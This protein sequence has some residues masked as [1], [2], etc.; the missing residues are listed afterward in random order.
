MSD[1][2]AVIRDG[3]TI[4]LAKKSSSYLESELATEEGFF[5]F[6]TSV[7]PDSE[8]CVDFSQTRIHRYHNGL[9]FSL[10]GL[11]EEADVIAEYMEICGEGELA[12]DLGAYC[13]VS[14][15]HLA[16]R[17]NRVVAVEPDPDAYACL[18]ENVGRHD[19]KNVTTLNI[20]VMDSDLPQR[21]CADGQPGSHIAWDWRRNRGKVIEV[22][23]KTLPGL[24]IQYGEPEFVKM[25]IE[26]A[27]LQVLGLGTLPRAVFAVDAT[28]L[29]DHQTTQER[30]ET[31][32]QMRGFK[33]KATEL[34]TVVGYPQNA[35]L[36]YSS[37]WPD[38]QKFRL[39]RG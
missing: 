19:L 2:I 18:V 24:M 4:Y 21:F 11:P 35:W 27:E 15:Y 5:K 16:K 25:D 3:K 39:V 10:C 23:A 36:E 9:E 32:L 26:G 6:Y 30:V 17:F 7:V 1:R 20:A 37:E 14:T 28:H 8:D 33:T 29:V 22:Y 12:F 13:G 31:L 34:G 38:N